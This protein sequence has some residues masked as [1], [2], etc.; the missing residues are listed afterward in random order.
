[1]KILRNRL[2]GLAF[3]VALLSKGEALDICANYPEALN[4]ASETVQLLKSEWAELEKLTKKL[5]EY[6]LREASRTHIY[7][8]TTPPE[9]FKCF[10][11]LLGKWGEYTEADISL[12]RLY[13]KGS[14]VH[15]AVIY[16]P[17]TQVSP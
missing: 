13:Q 11:T 4:H 5:P 7:A 14:M 16:K 12:L 3:L 15:Y 8:S 2:S 6:T 10:Q 1:M 9:Y 17:K